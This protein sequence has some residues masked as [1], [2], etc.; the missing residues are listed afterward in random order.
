MSGQGW[1]DK[2]GTPAVEGAGVGEERERERKRSYE[3]MISKKSKRSSKEQASISDLK[4]SVDTVYTPRKSCRNSTTYLIYSGRETL[5][6]W[7]VLDE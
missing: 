1:D 6:N 2:P 7:E 4:S 3:D 5:P